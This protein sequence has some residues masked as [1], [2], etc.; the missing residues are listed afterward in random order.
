MR[1]MEHATE[2]AATV[3]ASR[4]ATILLGLG[5]TAGLAVAA[6]GLMEGGEIAGSLPDGAVAAVNG[7]IVRIEE[8]ERAVRALASDRREPLG[9]EE[10]RHVLDR[11]IDEELLVQRG[12]ELGLMRHD[13]RVRGDIVSAV[14]DVIVS[15]TAAEV[16]TDEEV[17]AFYEESRDYFTRTG[18]AK[19]RQ[20]LVRGGQRVPMTRRG[21]VRWRQRHASMGAKPSRPSTRHS[22]IPRSPSCRAIICRRRSFAST[23]GLRRHRQRSR[24]RWVR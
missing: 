15:Q 18:R 16:A 1:A 13:R 20:I 3:P 2:P 24:W 9:D 12:L 8:Y 17:E 14:I 11:I 22:V 10:R 23:S 4:R 7:E 21:N 6:L 5:A 19:V